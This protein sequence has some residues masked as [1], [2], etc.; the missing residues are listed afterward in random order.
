MNHFIMTRFNLKLWTTDKNKMPVQTDEWL[1]KRFYL[2]ETYCLPSIINQTNQ[3]FEWICLFDI[4]TPKQYRSRIE[5]YVKRCPQLKPYYLNRNETQQ[6]LQ[7]FKD[8]I[9]GGGSGDRIITTYLDNDDCLKSNYCEYVQKLAQTE[10]L[11][12]IIS[13]EY[14]LQYFIE[15]GL[16]NRIY[17]PNNHFLTLIEANTPNIKTVWSISHYFLSNYKR[18]YNIKIVSEIKDMWIEII[19]D[20]NVDN[21]VKMTLRFHPILFP[22]Y[23]HAYGLD[24]NINPIT[25]I[26]VF[27]FRFCPRFFRQIIRR[28]K[29]KIK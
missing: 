23:L 26:C 14:G 22:S 19:H 13:F 2:F 7:F 11:N 21:D 17:Y 10:P 12:T 29:D 20:N 16:V 25:S 5:V 3:C 9:R 4:D 8:R 6:F 15:F 1:Q 18:D 28:L 24:K 27:I